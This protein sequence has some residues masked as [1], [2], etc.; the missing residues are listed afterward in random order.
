[1]EVH[2]VSVSLSQ[3]EYSQLVQAAGLLGIKPTTAAHRSIKH[4]L[5]ALSKEAQAVTSQLQSLQFIQRINQ[6]E[7]TSK[8][9]QPS[10]QV[11]T[12]PKTNIQRKQ[13]QKRAKKKKRMSAWA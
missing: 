9:S 12:K 11:P 4:G 7:T 5:M 3:S 13:E 10:P 8:P 2:R 1:M 6:N